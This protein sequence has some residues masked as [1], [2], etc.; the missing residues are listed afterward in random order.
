MAKTEDPMA[1]RIHRE[2][3]ESMLLASFISELEPKI[4]KHARIKDR[5]GTAE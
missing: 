5:Y 1:Q 4:G 3:T 2:N